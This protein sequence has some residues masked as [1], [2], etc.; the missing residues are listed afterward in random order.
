VHKCSA[1]DAKTIYDNTK[2][3]GA[4]TDFTA[5]KAAFERN[6]E[7]LGVTC[8]NIGGY[9]KDGVYKAGFGA[10]CTTTGLSTGALIGIIVG[11][12]AVVALVGVVVFL[13]LKGKKPKVQKSGGPD[14]A[15]VEA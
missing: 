5:V 4:S 11:A 10:G 15:A 9:S 14:V 13:Q 7:C 6:Y 3:G 1:A 8:A 12:V 2:I